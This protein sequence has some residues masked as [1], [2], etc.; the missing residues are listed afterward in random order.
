MGMTLDTDLKLRTLENHWT[1]AAAERYSCECA[2]LALEAI[3]EPDESVTQQIGLLKARMRGY[4]QSMKALDD[5]AN[6][7]RNEQAK[8]ERPT[9]APTKRT[10]GGKRPSA[11]KDPVDRP[12]PNASSKLAGHPT[13]AE[14]E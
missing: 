3:E 2:L 9:V 1:Q 11:R 14:G 13:Q 8:A 4:S 12:A 10:N 5:E 7:L 6:R